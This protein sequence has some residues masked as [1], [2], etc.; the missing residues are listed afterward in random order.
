[1][2]RIFVLL[3][4]I[5]FL[6]CNAADPSNSLQPNEPEELDI[7]I[8]ERIDGPAN[9]RNE[10][11]GE[12][13]LELFDNAMVDVS[14]LDND[15]YEVV[16]FAELNHSDYHD[17]EAEK[18]LIKAG[19]PIV[20]KDERIG[21]FK[22]DIKIRTY[23][24]NGGRTVFAELKGYT[25]KDNIKQY[26]IIERAIEEKLTDNERSLANWKPF[27]K[28]FGLEE[29]DLDFARTENI[30]FF[31]NS[32]GVAEMGPSPGPRV[33]LIFDEQTLIGFFHSRSINIEDTNTIQ[34]ERY[35]AA[36]FFRDYPEKKK[37]VI[38]DRLNKWLVYEMN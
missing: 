13:I 12:I 1:M 34:L 32:D 28:K 35:G 7:I 36:S 10:L 20:Q 19:R 9:V 16:I 4:V 22:K 17:G 31:G 11:N 23:L 24:G 18:T 33:V 26:T 27:I 25:H 30:T 29:E 38:I 21:T 37:K 8:Q 5:A 2:K 3:P 15:W 14:E 6:S